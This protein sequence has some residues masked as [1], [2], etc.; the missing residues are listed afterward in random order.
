MDRQ[1]GDSA[2]E[3]EGYFLEWVTIQ[4]PFFP[5]ELEEDWDS[6]SHSAIARIGLLQT[7]GSRLSNL[8]GVRATFR[9]LFHSESAGSWG[10]RKSQVLQGQ[11]QITESEVDA[12]P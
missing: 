1:L 12:L 11:A 2:V 4:A 5:P 8:L 6:L 9:G 7:I 3:L 10:I